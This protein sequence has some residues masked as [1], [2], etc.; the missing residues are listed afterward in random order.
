M[1]KHQGREIRTVHDKARISLDLAGIGPVIVNAMGIESQCGIAKQLDRIDRHGPA[2][3]RCPLRRDLRAW[4]HL[5]AGMGFPE[6]QI[7]SFADGRLVVTSD[8]N[9]VLDGAEHHPARAALLWR[10]PHQP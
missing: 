2:R 8:M 9:V 10:G 5:A 7:L 4:R 6:D 3:V 1:V